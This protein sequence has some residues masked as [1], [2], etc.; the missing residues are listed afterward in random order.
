MMGRAGSFACPES[1]ARIVDVDGPTT[2]ETVMAVERVDPED[3]QALA[4]A[5]DDLRVA[6]LQL[7]SIGCPAREDGQERLVLRLD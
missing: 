7:L 3:A 6:L 5:L 4:R 1:F 2:K